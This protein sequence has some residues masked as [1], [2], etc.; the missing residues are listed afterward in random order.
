MQNK[1]LHDKYNTELLNSCH[2]QSLL[3][4]A[5]IWESHKYVHPI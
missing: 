4:K 1:H 2:E 5:E 3:I